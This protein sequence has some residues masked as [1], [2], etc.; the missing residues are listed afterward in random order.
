MQSNCSTSRPPGLDHFLLLGLG[1]T[2]WYKVWGCFMLWKLIRDLDLASMYMCA[3]LDVKKEQGIRKLYFGYNLKPQTC[4]NKLH[5]ENLRKS[6]R[7]CWI[8]L[9][10]RLFAC[11][12]T[13]TTTEFS[14]K[15][16]SYVL[17]QAV[18]TCH[19][20]KNI[21]KIEIEQWQQVNYNLSLKCLNPFICS[22][23]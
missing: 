12:E 14:I 15:F 20:D 6:P 5:W 10:Y 19:R 7:D 11:F 9:C 22:I 21:P 8:F 1:L 17:L 23:K 18:K 16:F 13:T 3:V 2:L 4:E